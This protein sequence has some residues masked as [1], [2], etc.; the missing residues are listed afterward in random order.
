MSRNSYA[1]R[2]EPPGIC[3]GVDLK[4][5]FEVMFF[6][7]YEKPIV[8]CGEASLSVTVLRSGNQIKKKDM[9]HCF[10]QDVQ[11]ASETLCSGH[12]EQMA[13]LAMQC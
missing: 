1:A 13:I 10:L 8:W 11:H 4:G 2:K 9:Q 3:F 7:E 5:D 12:S 6:I